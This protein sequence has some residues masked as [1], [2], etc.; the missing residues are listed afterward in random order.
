MHAL[1]L[2]LESSDHGTFGLFMSEGF[3]CF[4]SELP[5]RDNTPQLSC[6]PEG[7]YT[8]KWHRSPKFGWCYKVFNVPGRNEILIHKGNYA[9]AVDKGYKTNSHGCLLP[10][11]KLGRIAGQKAGLIS[12]PAT[13]N[14]Y[15][16]FDKQSF[17]LEIKNANS[18]SSSVEQ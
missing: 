11:T 1:L 12:A 8:C 14:L 10:A 13:Q 9:G 7:S 6:I 17:T 16:H 3:S 2:R 15:S 4:I 18:D 5:W